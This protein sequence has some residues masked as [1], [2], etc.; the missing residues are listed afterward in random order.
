MWLHLNNQLMAVQSGVVWLKCLYCLKYFPGTPLWYTGMEHS[1]VAV[2]QTALKSQSI[3]KPSQ[4]MSLSIMSLLQHS[5]VNNDLVYVQCWLKPSW[6]FTYWFKKIKNMCCLQW[7]CYYVG[8]VAACIFIILF[9]AKN[10]WRSLLRSSE[11]YFLNREHFSA[12]EAIRDSGNLN[13]RS[14]PPCTLMLPWRPS[15]CDCAVMKRVVTR[16]RSTLAT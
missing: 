15:S 14:I 11:L 2:K 13:L 5:T 9:V 12:N 1:S 10:I 3:R 4:Q 6:D 16:H 7:F 8:L